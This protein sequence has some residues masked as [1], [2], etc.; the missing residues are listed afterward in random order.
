MAAAS[1]QDIIKQHLEAV[2]TGIIQHM[3]QQGRMASG[4][5]VA[6]LNVVVKD[7]GGFLEGAS[8]FL[9]MER[10]RG[11]G[12]VP[13]NFTSIIR[14]W[15][16]AKGISFQNL[17][18]KNGPPEQGLSR[19]SGAIAYSIMKN[20]TKLYRDKGYNDIFDTI[21]KDELEKIATE[22]AG[23]F[24]MEIDKIHQDNENT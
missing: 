11:P 6:S 20:G 17:I 14:D 16:I 24:D 10:G 9:A 1:I 3:S 15:I 7:K 22:S 5:S 19:L 13:R 23:V 12:D 8:S 4:K 2:K 18:P 21:L